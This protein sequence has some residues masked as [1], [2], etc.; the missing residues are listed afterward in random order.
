MASIR[1]EVSWILDRCKQ[2]CVF[3]HYE[4]PCSQHKTDSQIWVP[5]K[6]GSADLPTHISARMEVESKEVGLRDAIASCSHATESL[7]ESSANPT[8]AN[9]DV[10][11]PVE[12]GNATTV[13]PI[14]PDSVVL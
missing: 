10:L 6:G 13:D 1:V 2:C 5:K 12:I 14:V 7:C 3:G 9:N 8:L 11:P 4:K